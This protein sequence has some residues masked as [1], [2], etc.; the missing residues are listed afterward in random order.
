ML[1]QGCWQRALTG[2]NARSRTAISVLQRCITP[3]LNSLS[4][5]RRKVRRQP[6]KKCLIST[7]ASPSRAVQT[8]SH[9][10]I[11]RSLRELAKA[12]PPLQR[13][14]RARAELDRR[15]D[16]LATQFRASTADGARSSS[17]DLG[18]LVWSLAK[19]ST[20]CCCGH[21]A[22]LLAALTASPGALAAASNQTLCNALYGAAL[23]AREAAA[24]RG[25]GDADDASTPNGAATSPTSSASSP[26]WPSLLPPARLLAAACEPRLA[27]FNAQD[28]ANAWW[29][30]ATLSGL[31]PPPPREG[32]G[33][34]FV[35]PEGLLTGLSAAAARH[36]RR[37]PPPPQ[38]G[39]GA[40]GGS[41][42]GSGGGGGG[43]SGGAGSGGVCTPRGVAN[44]LWGACKLGHADERMLAAAVDLLSPLVRDLASTDPRALAS[45]LWALA[46]LK[47][48]P[49]GP[50]L[51]A[52]SRPAAARIRSFD[53]QSL[54]NL[55]WAYGTSGVAAPKLFAAAADEIARRADWMGL[56]FLSISLWAFATANHL[57]PHLMAA[58]AESLTGASTATAAPAAA[59]AVKGRGRGR[60]Q[61]GGGGGGDG[62]RGGVGG[63][64]AGDRLAEAEAEAALAAR[65][66]TCDGRRTQALGNLAWSYACLGARHD[67]LMAALAG[68]AAAAAP[69]LNAQELSNVLYGAARLMPYMAD[70]HPRVLDALLSE[71]DR[72]LAGTR[73]NRHN[74]PNR[75][76]EL[77]YES[78][79]AN[80]QQLTARDLA[81]LSWSVAILSPASPTLRR[82]LDAAVAVAAVAVA[83]TAA[84]PMAAAADDDPAAAD[85][86]EPLY[87]LQSQPYNLFG[88][89][90]L[91]GANYAACLAAAAS[92]D[93]VTS[94]DG[95]AAVGVAAAAAAAGD[96]DG[97]G[98]AVGAV[99]RAAAAAMRQAQRA[100]EAIGAP[101]D[102]GAAADAG[103]K[104]DGGGG[105]D[106]DGGGA[107]EEMV[108]FGPLRS[109]PALFRA[110]RD[111]WL[112]NTASTKPSDL[113]SA[114]A[115]ALRDR[116]SS[117]G[118]GG[119]VTAV[120]EEALSPDRMAR[121]DLLVQYDGWLVML[122]V[123]GPS[124]FAVELASYRSDVYGNGG[125]GDGGGSNG[126]DA[127][128][129]DV[130]GGA[131]LGQGGGDVDMGRDGG[132]GGGVAAAT[133][134][135]AAAVT[136]GQRGRGR[137]PAR[138][139]SR[140]G[141]RPLGDTLLRNRFLAASLGLAANGGGGDPRVDSSILEGAG[142]VLSA[143]AGA[144]AC[145]SAETADPWIIERL[146][147]QLPSPEVGGGVASGGAGRECVR[148]V[149]LA[150]LTFAQ[151]N[152]GSRDKWAGC[153][154]P[155]L[156][157]VVRGYDS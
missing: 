27:S 127:D 128:A 103:G 78:A 71:V 93:V 151:W 82:L 51:S 104:S 81:M 3:H 50:L 14:E 111:A 153:L 75:Q 76:R 120:V 84:A 49:A 29:A 45:C 150:S 57:Q 79:A 73:A 101:T 157:R 100:A 80:G 54:S 91:Y 28:T 129:R 130:D 8:A 74:R 37:S 123:D 126:R 119:G 1:A 99:V 34:G 152:A 24:G 139:P 114:V 146:L 117:G 20:P 70:T 148:G 140:S 122:E 46:A 116:S 21:A 69:A 66:A 67:P 42:G 102:G 108:R 95:A 13:D 65:L 64:G 77:P 88:L 7:A 15:I 89:V 138:S 141:L 25:S 85:G 136:A 12:P 60:G 109:C 86:G 98:G 118:G 22:P 156:D 147:E 41:G 143:A 72:R 110:C 52:A 6:W 55:L 94:A 144:S 4:F 43:G 124:H 35:P 137:K 10:N 63:D 134:A 154:A 9:A 87:E 113:Q 92:A 56:Q 83:A 115:A 121:V 68:R 53:D 30:I 39:T 131:E 155:L 47:F 36:M 38:G 26:S 133:A 2:S 62:G 44:M 58:V 17:R 23:L 97:D 96:G 106:D 61:R 135:V 18:S 5:V 125:G 112:L 32:G 31:P 19:L 48:P 16:D 132:R 107:E 105:G 11:V 33:P 90:Q 59:A 149:V 142:G 40:S 145:C